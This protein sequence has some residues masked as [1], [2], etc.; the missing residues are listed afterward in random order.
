MSYRTKYLTLG[1]YVMSKLF[2]LLTLSYALH[3][4]IVLITN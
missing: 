3:I 4:L 1:M 2:S